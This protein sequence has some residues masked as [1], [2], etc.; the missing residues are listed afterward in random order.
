MR[1]GWF[2]ERTEDAVGVLNTTF[3]GGGMIST[4]SSLE[5]TK[6]GVPLGIGAFATLFRFFNVLGDCVM[7]VLGRE[8]VETEA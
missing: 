6:I 3:L 4:S 2:E 8:G 7:S 1:V 5:R